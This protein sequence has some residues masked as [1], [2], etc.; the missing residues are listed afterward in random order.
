MA[1]LSRRDLTVPGVTTVQ[2]SVSDES[3]IQFLRYKSATG[4]LG[5]TL[6]T[7]LTGGPWRLPRATATGGATWQGETA[8]APTAEAAFDAITLA[9][10]RISANSIISKQLVAQS[11]P[12]IEQFI[13]DELSQAISTEVDRVA[14]NGSGVA[15]VPAGVLALPVNAAATYAYNARSPNVVFGGPASWSSILKFEDTLDAGAQVHNDGTYGWCAAPDVRVKWMGVQKAVNYP[16]YLWEQP[17]DQLDGTIAGRKA[18]STSQMPAGSI[19]FG[20]WSDALIGTWAALELLLSLR[21][22]IV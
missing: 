16:S 11:Q 19:I 22:T 13:I 1:A 21:T 14:L 2:T 3:P 10:S 17:T 18:V 20:R 5:A 15:P 7:D 9:P 8:T 12:A 6:L 4:G